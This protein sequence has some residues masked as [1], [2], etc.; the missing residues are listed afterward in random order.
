MHRLQEPAKVVAKVTY[1]NSREVF[2]RFEIPKGR[3]VIIPTTFEPGEETNF[4][5]RLYTDAQTY[6]H[7]MKRS[8]PQKIVFHS[9]GCKTYPAVFVRIG[10]VSAVG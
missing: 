1:I 4:L 5:L 7:R 3:Y 10:V 8:T 2:K 6:C 9:L